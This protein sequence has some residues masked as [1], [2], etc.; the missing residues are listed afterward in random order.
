MGRRRRGQDAL[1]AGRLSPCRDAICVPRGAR[2]LPVRHAAAG[3]AL[4][5]RR[6]ARGLRDHDAARRRALG[7][8]FRLQASRH[9]AEE[10]GAEAPDLDPHRV[11]RCA[12][13]A[14]HLRRIGHAHRAG[15]QAR[16]RGDRHPVRRRWPRNSPSRRPNSRT[17]PTAACRTRTW[18]NAQASTRCATSRQC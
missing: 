1:G 10:R 16:Q 12:G 17:C 6:P 18:L 9:L 2:D 11:S 4:H 3:R 13:P 8:V 5:V 14:A 7:R 15:V